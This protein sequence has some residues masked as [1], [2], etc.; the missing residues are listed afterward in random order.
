MRGP[1]ACSSAAHTTVFPTPVSVPVTNTPRNI[2]AGSTTSH[3]SVGRER[4]GKD[5][6]EGIEIRFGDAGVDRDP[7]TCGTRRDR[8][9]TNGADVEAAGLNRRRDGHRPLVV[10]DANRDDLRVAALRRGSDDACASQAVPKISSAMA[11]P[12][13]AI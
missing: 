1:R 5:A 3:L 7:E 10:A 12:M 11:Q 9:W 8:R 13:P 4:V 2:P 6:D